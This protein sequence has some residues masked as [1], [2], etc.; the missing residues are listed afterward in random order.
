MNEIKSQ[1][2]NLASGNIVREA[3]AND[4]IRAN[5]RERVRAEGKLPHYTRENM[6]QIVK[7]FLAEEEARKAGM[8]ETKPSV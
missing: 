5:V 2:L 4:E 1:P 8:E 6:T 3:L 7:A